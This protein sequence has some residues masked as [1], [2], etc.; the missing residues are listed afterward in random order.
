M[1]RLALAIEEQIA[2]TLCTVLLPADGRSFLNGRP[3]PVFIAP[4]LPD[5]IQRGHALTSV[6]QDTV[7]ADDK[8]ILTADGELI[9]RLLEALRSAGIS[10]AAGCSTPIFSAAGSVAGILILFSQDGAS[11]PDSAPTGFCSQH[12]V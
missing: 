10:F 3:A 9:D 4:G 6:L 8:H 1:E 7:T 12:H 5:E 11:H 2:G